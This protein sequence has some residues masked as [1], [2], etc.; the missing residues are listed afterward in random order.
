MILR[1][2][3]IISSKIWLIDSPHPVLDLEA[4][5]FTDDRHSRSESRSTP[6]DHA[7]YIVNSPPVGSELTKFYVC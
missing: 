6:A 1:N 7:N 5:D 2:S 3:G 4:T